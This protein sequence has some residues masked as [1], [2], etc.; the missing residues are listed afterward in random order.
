[1]S[2]SYRKGRAFEWRVR[3]YLRGKGYLVVRSAASKGPFDLVA[4]RKGEVLLVQCKYHGYISKKER[5]TLVRVARMVGA[6]PVLA[7]L[8]NANKRKILITRLDV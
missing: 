5:E 2:K 7:S 4:L 1:M 6:I 3:D 8:N